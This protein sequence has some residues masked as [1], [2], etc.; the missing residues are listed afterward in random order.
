M[1]NH[2]RFIY[3]WLMLLFISAVYGQEQQLET[4]PSALQKSTRMWSEFWCSVSRQAVAQL[5]DSGLQPDWKKK[6]ASQSGSLLQLLGTQGLEG[7]MRQELVKGFSTE[8]LEELNQFLESPVGQK[9]VA[10]MPGVQAKAVQQVLLKQLAIPVLAQTET[11]IEE[12]LALLPA[13]ERKQ[14][15]DAIASQPLET[16]LLLGKWYTQ[17]LDEAGN[18]YWGWH[19][20]R[21]SGLSR[22]AGVELDHDERTYLAYDGIAAWV[23]KGRLLAETTLEFP[24]STDLYV[25]ESIDENQMRYRCVDS[26]TPFDEWMVLTDQRTPIKLPTKP[27]GYT[28]LNE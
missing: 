18:G 25:I 9:F 28:D 22:S 8:E 7:P 3:P 26:E 16:D 4:N 6:L 12:T 10:V 17:D 15:Q 1:C 13:P 21:D 24:E 14:L 20:K 11:N 27:A 19:E 5:D 2:R 23:L